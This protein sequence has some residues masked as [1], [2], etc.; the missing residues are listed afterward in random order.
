MRSIS[1]RVVP[2][3]RGI[4]VTDQQIER[5]R[6]RLERL[7]AEAEIRRLVHA[8]GYFIDKAHYTG[9]LDCFSDDGEIVFLNGIFRRQTGGFDRLL[10]TFLRRN[11]SGN[12][13]PIRGLLIDHPMTQ[14]IVDIGDDLDTATAK[15]RILE[16]SGVHDS[17]DAARG[18]MVIP[19]PLEM[20]GVHVVKS[21]PPPPLPPSEPGAPP[22][23]R[24]WIGG[25]AL[26]LQTRKED[27]IW[28]L[29][30][31]EYRIDWNVGFNSGWAH[32][33]VRAGPFECAYPHDP[34]GPDALL[35]MPVH[36]PE[37]AMPDI[38]FRHPVTRQRIP[39]AGQ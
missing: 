24:Q 5:A 20:I 26:D 23:P 28:K 6:S 25:A 29:V 33:I 11:P 21:D 8:Y 12:S 19:Q 34:N 39:F 14:L 15:I 30:R 4:A 37:R 35:E 13:L 27:G 2:A 16:F 38:R 17:N 3:G 31:L 18:E 1:R 22:P 32:D 10:T 7:E 36:W 9:A